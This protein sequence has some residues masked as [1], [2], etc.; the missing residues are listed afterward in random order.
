MTLALSP[1][2]AALGAIATYSPYITV[3]CSALLTALVADVACAQCAA[4]N[5]TAELSVINHN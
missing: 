4:S 2:V 5:L 1:V 3:R